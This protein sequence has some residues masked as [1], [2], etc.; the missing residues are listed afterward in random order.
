MLNKEI[1]VTWK[2]RVYRGHIERWIPFIGT[3]IYE[4]Y[5]TQPPVIRKQGTIVDFTTNIFG[6]TFAIIDS[7]DNKIVKISIDKLIVFHNKKRNG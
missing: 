2:E 1:K 3:K 4:A 6:K 7:G 5:V